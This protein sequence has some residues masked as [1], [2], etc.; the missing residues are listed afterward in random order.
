MQKL[1]AKIY[2][3]SNSCGGKNSGIMVSNEN[4][5]RAVTGRKSLWGCGH[6]N[7]YPHPLCIW[8]L[9]TVWC[10][11]HGWS[12]AM[13]RRLVSLRIRSLQCLHE[14]NSYVNVFASKVLWKFVLGIT[15]TSCVPAARAVNAVMAFLCALPRSNPSIVSVLGA[16]S[17]ADAADRSADRHY[18]KRTM[19]WPTVRRISGE[20]WLGVVVVSALVLI[21]EVAPRWARLVAAWVTVDTLTDRRI[22]AW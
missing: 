5:W 15:G 6:T 18:D 16:A 4:F 3:E 7:F 12:Q 22:T 10:G 11:M 1:V 14:D 19:D 13:R 9:D 8:C 17:V 21:N 20:W 2:R